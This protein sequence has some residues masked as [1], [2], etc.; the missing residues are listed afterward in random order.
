MTWFYEFI[1]LNNKFFINSRTSKSEITIPN[2]IFFFGI[3][4]WN[5]VKPCG[6]QFIWPL[7]Y[8]WQNFPTTTRLLH[9]FQYLHLPHRKLSAHPETM[10]RASWHLLYL[11]YPVTHQCIL[12]MLEVHDNWSSSSSNHHRH[13]HCR[14]AALT[15]LAVNL[16]IVYLSP[17]NMIVQKPK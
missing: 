5:L 7:S 6:E 15:H 2:S 11:L 12:E 8:L 1:N 4:D 16:K 9:Q 3:V 14:V 10:Q 17:W 13:C